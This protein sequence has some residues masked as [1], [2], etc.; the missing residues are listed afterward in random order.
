MLLCQLKIFFKLNNNKKIFLN[1][2]AV[3]LLSIAIF[4]TVAG[5]F[6]FQYLFVTIKKNKSLFKE[7]GA[8]HGHG[9]YHA[10]KSNEVIEA[11]NRTDFSQV[12]RTM[13]HDNEKSK[14]SKSFWGKLKSFFG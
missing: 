2:F 6:E 5:N 10:A 13:K 9:S 3:L 8:G 11:F 4:F 1:R 14:K 7:I 12:N